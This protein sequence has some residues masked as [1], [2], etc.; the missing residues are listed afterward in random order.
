[1]KKCKGTQFSLFRISFS[2][3]SIATVFLGGCRNDRAVGRL[4]C[5]PDHLLVRGKTDGAARVRRG[6]TG[7]SPKP[8]PRL[9]IVWFREDRREGLR[10]H[11]GAW[12]VIQTHPTH[13]WGALRAPGTSSERLGALALRPYGWAGA[14]LNDPPRHR[15]GHSRDNLPLSPKVKQLPWHRRTI[16]VQALSLVA[17]VERKG[18]LP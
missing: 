3:L 18:A 12:W 17:I 16:G 13:L 8:T 6:A 2:C 14:G 1:M 7:R 11:E 4:A 9:A 15:Q 10:G 5:L